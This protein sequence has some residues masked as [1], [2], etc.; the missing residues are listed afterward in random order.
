[1]NRRLLLSGAAIAA[2]TPILAGSNPFD[3]AFAAAASGEHPHSSNDHSQGLL[4]KN[5]KGSVDF[6]GDD[7]KDHYHY[8]DDYYFKGEILVSKFRYG[9]QLYVEG[10]ITG[11]IYKSGRRGAIATFKKEPF[12]TY[13]TLTS[14]DDWGKW[15]SDDDWWHHRDD[16]AC[17]DLVLDIGKIRLDVRYY[18]RK[19]TVDIDPNAVRLDDIRTK[20]R[21]SVADLRMLLCELADLLD[22]DDD[23]DGHGH[24]DRKD[25]RHDDRRPRRRDVRAVIR[26]INDL[27]ARCLFVVDARHYRS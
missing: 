21:C 10:K 19:V 17:R 13:C 25:E 5:V 2:A 4:L 9:K 15:S 27:L 11:S 12:R 7:R 3:V 26:D 6:R 16:H 22:S 20:G 23:D 14:R 18:G 8:E 24:D 1:M